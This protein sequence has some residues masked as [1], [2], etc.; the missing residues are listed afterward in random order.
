[1]QEQSFEKQVREKLEELSFVPSRS[2]WQHVEKGLHKKR[3]RRRVAL[4]LLPLL[5]VPASYFIWEQAGKDRLSTNITTL[6]SSG[7]LPGA[8]SAAANTTGST[9]EMPRKSGL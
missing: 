2:V 3:E 9:R 5:L 1:M 8:P 7:S 6:P 4:W